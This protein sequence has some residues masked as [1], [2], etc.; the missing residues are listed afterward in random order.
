M[1]KIFQFAA[2]AAFVAALIQPA[3]AQT[4]TTVS[5][6]LYSPAGNALSGTVTI[7]NNATFTA[8]D[9]TVVPKGAVGTAT[10]VNGAFSV[11]LVPNAGS[12]PSGSSY[13]VIYSLGSAYL[14]ETWV[15]PSSASPVTLAEVRTSPAPT[16]SVMIA[17]SQLPV[18]INSSAIEDK[19]G[20]V[21]NVKAYGAK[22]DGAT[23]DSAA[24]AAAA[25]AAAAANGTVFFPCGTY[26][27]TLTL[28]ISSPAR[29]QG[30]S[31][32]CATVRAGV[33]LTGD[34][35]SVAAS[36]VS[37]RQLTLDAA[38]HASRAIS[39]STAQSGITIDQVT[40]ENA[41]SFDF[42]A[43]P[44]GVSNLLVTDSTFIGGAPGDFYISVVGAYTASS[45]RVVN[46]VM[47]TTS[48]PL[49]LDTG[50][51]HVSMYVVANS[52][53]TLSNVSISN[54]QIYFPILAS[55]ESDGIVI[56]GGLTSTGTLTNST[57]A[58]NLI[59]GTPGAAPSYYSNAL[60]VMDAD[61]LTISSNVIINGQQAIEVEPDAANDVIHGSITGN[62]VS[63]ALTGSKNAIDIRAYCL[64]SAV[65]N[66]IQSGS[67]GAGISQAGEGVVSGNQ[68]IAASNGVVVNNSATPVSG[69]TITV[70]SST[71]YPIEMRCL[72][73]SPCL[74]D[75]VTSNTIHGH[76]SGYG[77]Y[78]VNS[79][80]PFANVAVTGNAM[81][82]SYYGILFNTTGDSGTLGNNTFSSVTKPYLNL[83]AQ[84]VW[85]QVS[86][87]SPSGSCSNGSRY[88][89]TAGGAGT[90]FYGCEAGAWAA[91]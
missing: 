21:F 28:T 60:E 30:A 49:N 14:H 27:T 43:G 44:E 22:G 34:M 84:V 87:G 6:T 70:S 88:I 10:V 71:G 36:G 82:S 68:I 35:F 51:A 11:S 39:I 2:C 81:D 23:D 38:Q 78:F 50:Q 32:S 80:S 79:T 15:V 91:K 54:N 57:I 74:S 67:A 76:A 56:S 61:A 62:Y 13:N 42:Y 17:A 29:F 46:S 69:N 3:F 12:T 75:S 73:T 41:E 18:I 64:Y 48:T 52:G 1:K 66:Y 33:S 5:D 20:Q 77:I 16:P 24:I 65:G 31:Q 37:F 85:S 55:Q 86:S 45:I 9:G 40:A 63:D 26:L 25:S 53:G 90:T 59:E 8:A 19:G 47:G 58:S 89:N 7:T 72:Q 4:R 83:P